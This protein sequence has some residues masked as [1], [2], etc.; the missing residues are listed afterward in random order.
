MQNLKNQSLKGLKPPKGLQQS[1]SGHSPHAAKQDIKSSSTTRL[2][3]C[4]NAMF[5]SSA[6]YAALY[7]L[8]R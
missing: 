6:T 3:T 1:K 4:G 2:T 8:E 5:N 7:P